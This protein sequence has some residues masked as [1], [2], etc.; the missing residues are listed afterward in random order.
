MRPRQAAQLAGADPAHALPQTP[1]VIVESRATIPPG[2][3]AAVRGWSALA[4]LNPTNRVT[5]SR[6]PLWQQQQLDHHPHPTRSRQPPERLAGIPQRSVLLCRGARGPPN[7]VRKAA[8]VAA[9]RGAPGGR[10]GTKGEAAVL[11]LADAHRPQGRGACALMRA[12][13]LGHRRGAAPG[14]RAMPGSRW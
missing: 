1:V 10:Q 4:A 13:G 3:G 11:G 9:A 7:A 5:V 14:L 8:R 6:G 12:D 2:G